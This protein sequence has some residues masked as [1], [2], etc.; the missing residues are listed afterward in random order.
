MPKN[1]QPASKTGGYRHSDLKPTKGKGKGKAADEEDTGRKRKQVTQKGRSNGAANYTKDDYN[2]LFPILRHHKPIGQRK[3]ATVTE[4]FN[5]RAEEIGRPTRFQKSLETKFKQ[6]VK[7]TKPMG[8]AELPPHVEGALEIEEMINKKAGT[9]D[10]DDEDLDEGDK[11][12]SDSDSDKE[13]EP[14]VKKVKPI[15]CDFVDTLSA[16]LDPAAQVERDERRSSQALQ[17]TSMLTMSGQ[18]QDL[19]RS[20]DNL[21]QRLEEAQR[22][23]MQAERC[24]DRAE[25]R[26][27]RLEMLSSVSDRSSGRFR[28]TYQQHHHDRELDREPKQWV[29]REVRYPEGGGLTS[30]HDMKELDASFY[31]RN[32]EAGG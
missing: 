17:A 28:C 9:R 4:E 29:R 10:L 14:P 26:A 21:R 15:T 11:L 5:E 31:Q 7:T 19:Q 2:I 27:D 22:D 18:I 24:A 1:V 23:L 32:I 25:M 12:D 16:A 13:N 3:W 6:L 30:W 20:N 8:D